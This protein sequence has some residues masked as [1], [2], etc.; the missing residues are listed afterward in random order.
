MKET[1][2]TYCR[3]CEPNCGLKATVVDGKLTK[4]TGNKNH[5]ISKGYICARGLATLDIHHD[6]DRIKYPMKQENGEFKRVDWDSAL[7]DIGKR[8]KD[9]REKYGNNAIA[10]YFGNP[11]AFDYAFTAYMPFGVNALKSRNIFSAGSQDCNNKFIASQQV[12]GSSLIHPVPDI[13]NMDFFII[14][15]SN[16][17]ISK[18]SFISLANPEKR[19][20]A[21]EKRGGRVIIIDPRKTETA[22]LL[23][24]HIFIKPDTDIFLMMAMLDTIFTENLYDKG[25]VSKHTR[26]FEELKNMVSDYPAEKASEITG[27]DKEV[28]QTLARDF[29]NA[30]NAGIHASIGINHGT[31]GT[32]GY[33][34]VHCL[35]A[36]TGRID[37]K[38]SM[39]FC[40]NLL[41]FPKFYKLVD[42]T[43]KHHPS[44]IGDF[45][46]VMETLPAGI[47]ADEILTHGKDQIKALIVISGNPMLTVP[48][49]DRLEKAFK[50][51]DLVV[52]A[53]LFI[54]ETGG[55]SDYVLPSKDFYEHWDFSVNMTMFNP[56]SV[57]YYTEEVVKAEGE[58][59]ELWLILHEIL[60]VAGFPFAG[61][62][63]LSPMAR[64]TDAIGKK[65][66]GRAEPLSFQPE[67]MLK[68]LLASC[69]I[70]FKKLKDS[71]H[72]M[73]LK[74]HE[75]GKFYKNLILTKGKKIQLAPLDFIKQ[76]PVLDAFF[77]K[78]KNRNGFKLIGQRQK[79]TH[80]SW[81]HNVPSFMEK[82]K[83][84]CVSIN[85]GDAERLQILE[86]DTIEVKSKTGCVQIPAKIVDTLMP[87]VISIPHGWGHDMKSGLNVA[88]KYP[89]VNVNKLFASGP[90]N[91]E[92]FCGMAILTGIPVE[93]QKV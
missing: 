46:P 1:K 34:L 89:G 18:M 8:L 13:D 91:L 59:K 35:N 22:Q 37:K 85:R 71:K 92:H 29:A 4:V 11:I 78:E 55:L 54:N 88:K 5:I 83:T 45:Q 15:G 40:Q 64:A 87:G 68:A 47:M 7:K 24:E 56:T 74:D 10:M 75:T 80:N 38:G 21:I 19:L 60:R 12:Y 52:S 28:I 30:G 26:G 39:I 2:Y 50:S 61:T 77:E 14:W 44:R 17:T 51:L 49:T 9:I 79:R 86:G 3:I 93:I 36:V 90:D 58:R 42:K 70:S 48:D 67:L 6:P 20:K 27:I 33:W 31:F 65:I 73:K 16:P 63:L 76:K 43:R 62:R 25:V 41:N 66:F 32:L 72:G 69:G 82:S 23:G 84:N 81:L 57:L 53:D